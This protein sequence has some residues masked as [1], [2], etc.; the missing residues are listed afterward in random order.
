[1]SFKNRQGVPVCPHLSDP[2]KT[3]GLAQVSHLRKYPAAPGAYASDSNEAPQ[4]CSLEP[5]TVIFPRLSFTGPCFSPKYG[6][7]PLGAVPTNGSAGLVMATEPV[8]GVR[9]H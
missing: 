9:W 3:N 7:M 4:I 8:A 1:M 6:T 2:D 5:L